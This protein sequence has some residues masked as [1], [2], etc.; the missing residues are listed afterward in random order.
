MEFG[1]G[2]ETCHGGNVDNAIYERDLSEEAGESCQS[3]THKEQ[4]LWPTLHKIRTAA[5]QS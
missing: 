2:N 3:D 4:I 1:D 5:L